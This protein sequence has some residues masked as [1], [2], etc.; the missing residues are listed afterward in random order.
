LIGVSATGFLDIDSCYSTLLSE[1]PPPHL[2]ASAAVDS[3]LYDLRSGADK[4]G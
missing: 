4:L 3:D 2:Q 1:I